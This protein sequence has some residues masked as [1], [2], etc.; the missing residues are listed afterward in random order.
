MASS[1]P[2]GRRSAP[3]ASPVPD[4]ASV[5][6]LASAPAIDPASS[7]AGTHVDAS[8]WDAALSGWTTDT[9]RAVLAWGFSMTAALLAG[10]KATRDVQREAA[11]R[12]EAACLAAGE[13][14]QSTRDGLQAV[15]VQSDWLRAQNDEAMRLWTRLAEIGARTGAEVVQRTVEGWSSTSS[16]ALAGLGRWAEVQAALPTT[17]EALQAEA[18]HVA[19]PLAAGPLAWP[20]QEAW[21]QGMSFASSMWNDWVDWSHRG[22]GRVTGATVH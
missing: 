8:S 13:R 15:G 2:Q 5:E 1:T 3:P 21:R 10:A 4:V 9:G 22:A 19:N 17:P 6:R 20:A 14:L 18:E 7:A 16:V 12:A 11:E